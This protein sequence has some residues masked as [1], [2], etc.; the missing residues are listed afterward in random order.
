M[1]ALSRED[2]LEAV[3]ELYPANTV[4]GGVK[5]STVGERLN[6]S[7]QAA[8]TQLKK[9]VEEGRLRRLSGLRGPT[10]APCGEE[11]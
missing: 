7:P 4:T 9:L 5:A 3:H 2:Y 8:R 11:P 1:S 10:Y 6:R